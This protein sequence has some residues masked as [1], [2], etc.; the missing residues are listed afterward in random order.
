MKNSLKNG[1]NL[2][3]GSWQKQ[4]VDGDQR[5][6]L[7]NIGVALACE[8][9]PLVSY[10]KLKKN[11]AINAFAV[12]TSAENNINLIV[13]GVGKI[14]A[15]AAVSFLQQLTGNQTYS[16]YLNVG[17]A[18]ASDYDIGELI[19]A[20]KITDAAADI[21]YYP[22]PLN[23]KAISK[24][25]LMTHEQPHNIYPE[26][27]MLDM[28]AAGFFQAANLFVTKEQI[29]IAKIISDNDLNSQQCINAKMVSEL[30]QQKLEKIDN[31]VQA[32]LSLSK[33]EALLQ[34]APK[35]YEDFLNCW[36]FTAQQQIQLKEAL[37]RFEIVFE[38]DD[39]YEQ[40]KQENS[41]KGVLKILINLTVGGLE[42]AKS[43]LN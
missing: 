17:I 2:H 40:C 32:L 35:Y 15:A 1:T 36:H 38:Q 33:Q 16:C 22:F 7:L 3:L 21:R 8:A 24:T 20:N 5:G 14:K 26:K 9:K 29:H 42:S 25:A 6:Q 31:I 12:Y 13:S 34:Q 10:Y 43:H 18:G 37:R 30:I 11:L 4:P 23:L 39:A 19:L 27:I 41:A 28:E